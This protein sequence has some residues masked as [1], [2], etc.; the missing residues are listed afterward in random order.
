V[1]H[2]FIEALFI[3]C[4]S[5]QSVDNQYNGDKNK[6]EENFP[7]TNFNRYDIIDFTRNWRL[8]S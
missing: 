2:F 4:F 8:P 5:E 1:C 3:N 7:K 6:N